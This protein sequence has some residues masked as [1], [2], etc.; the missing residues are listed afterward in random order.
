[1]SAADNASCSVVGCTSQSALR[2]GMC[3]SHYSKWWREAPMSER[4]PVQ[5]PS[6]EERFWSKVARGDGCW[7]WLGTLQTSGYGTF[8]IGRSGRVLAHRWAYEHLVGPIPAG[9]TIDHLCRNRACVNPSHM[10]VVTRGENTRRALLL[11][12]P[13]AQCA[14]GHDFTA[15]NTYVRPANSERACRACRRRI[16]RA[17]RAKG[18]AA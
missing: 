13:K 16:D 9:L 18:R 17:R 1:M 2:R 6:V 12:A 4:G 14:H 15:E 11:R 3:N 5:R 7:G 8:P 10:E